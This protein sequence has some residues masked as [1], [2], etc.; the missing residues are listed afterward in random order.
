MYWPS[1]HR[2]G[3]TVTRRHDSG[4]RECRTRR[5]L[6]AAVDVML[7]WIAEAE[8]AAPVRMTDARQAYAESLRARGLL[9]STVET[10]D[11]RLRPL[12]GL[13]DHVQDLDRGVVERRLAQLDSV[14][15]KRHTLAALHSA[16][17]YWIARRWLQRDPTAGVKVTG[18]MPR[19]KL[20]LT[21][22]EVRLLL[23]ALQVDSA[24]AST[25]VAL[26]VLLGLRSGEIRKLRVRDLDLAGDPPTVTVASGWTGGRAAGG[27]HAGK[28]DAA[29]RTRPVDLPWL[30]ARLAVLADQRELGD[31]VFRSPQ[32]RRAGRGFG[33]KWLTDCTR[34]YA[35]RAELEEERVA[36]LC[37]HG[38]RGTWKR[39]AELSGASAADTARAAGWTS[40]EVGRLNYAPGS[41]EHAGAAN[42]QDLYAPRQPGDK[43]PRRPRK[44]DR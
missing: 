27:R 21:P 23:G 20:S 16:A 18:R 36:A 5:T 40:P 29:V 28:T 8:A 19:G 17:A 30:A 43:T 41:D 34:R 14:A 11:S 24:P 4:A 38:L 2:D 12:D 39:L 3:Y 25:A 26:A 37:A 1:S 9:A 44:G 33:K 32:K 35:E 13:V 31:L 15:S 10:A 7:D 22:R 42:V 6:E